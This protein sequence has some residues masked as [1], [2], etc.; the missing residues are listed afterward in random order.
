MALGIERFK[1]HDHQL[2]VAF[3]ASQF[4][5]FKEAF[6][7]D[8]IVRF[9]SP[10]HL[11]KLAMFN[12]SSSDTKAF[13]DCSSLWSQLPSEPL[14]PFVLVVFSFDVQLA[15]MQIIRHHFPRQVAVQVVFLPV[16]GDEGA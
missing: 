6:I 10:P 13:L 3:N 9:I 12:R 7:H 1:T 16:Y 11:I 2:T 5:C 14:V 8:V 15:V 4:F